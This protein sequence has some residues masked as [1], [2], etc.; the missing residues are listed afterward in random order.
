M[1]QK[2]K[3]NT[4]K[5]SSTVFSRSLKNSSASRFPKETA[6]SC[7]T[8]SP[9][10]TKETKSELTYQRYMMSTT[11]KVLIKCTK[12]SISPRQMRRKLLMIWAA[13]LEFFTVRM[14]LTIN[15]CKVSQWS[16]LPRFSSRYQP[17]KK[18]TRSWRRSCARLNK[19]TE[20]I[21]ATWHLMSWMT[22]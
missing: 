1:I 15:Y 5:Y 7:K 13:T 12:V 6:G 8:F 14:P 16:N 9:V 11:N 18:E 2:R 17:K 3:M 22:F 4:V 20:T 21:T 19:L 10:E